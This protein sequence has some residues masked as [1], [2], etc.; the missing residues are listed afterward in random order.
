MKGVKTR[1][2]KLAHSFQ[3]V[4]MVQQFSLGKVTG[5]LFFL[6]AGW[7]ASWLEDFTSVA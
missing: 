3:D 5:P 6:G 1:S 7:A 4:D 2:R